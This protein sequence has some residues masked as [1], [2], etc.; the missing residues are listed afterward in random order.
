[1][2][3]PHELAQCGRFW[4]R[5]PNGVGLFHKFTRE[6]LS[7]DDAILDLGA[8]LAVVSGCSGVV[9]TWKATGSDNPIANASFCQDHT[10]TANAVYGDKK[11]HSSSGHWKVGQG[12][13]KLDVDGN[14]R[15]Y[16]IDVSRT[17]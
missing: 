4:K 10:F 15:E 3:A 9:G 13:L 12:K 2:T 17:S 5:A 1:M 16:E 7:A 6:V 8:I 14:T 11:S